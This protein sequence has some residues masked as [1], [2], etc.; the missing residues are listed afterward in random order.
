MFAVRRCQV[1]FK[2]GRQT[3]DRCTSAVNFRCRQNSSLLRKLI[4]HYSPLVYQK[5]VH[6]C[7]RHE[8]ISSEQIYR[9]LADLG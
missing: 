3:K 5:Q 2:G 4:I 9:D 8:R 6:C 7:I 1:G